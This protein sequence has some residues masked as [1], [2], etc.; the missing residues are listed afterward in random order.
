MDFFI[1]AT[2]SAATITP[3]VLHMR[4][5]NLIINSLLTSINMPS[6]HDNIVITI[7]LN[8]SML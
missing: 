2:N 7:I 3:Y 4:L 8:C 5:T 6:Y 1:T